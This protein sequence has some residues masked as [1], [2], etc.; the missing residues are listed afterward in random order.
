MYCVGADTIK[1]EDFTF[2]RTKNN[3]KGS[4]VSPFQLP[5]AM[6]PLFGFNSLSIVPTP[7][8]ALKC[9]RVNS[10]QKIFVNVCYHDDAPKYPITDP[11]LCLGNEN[12]IGDTREDAI[13]TYDVIMHSSLWLKINETPDAEDPTA[14]QKAVDFKE[15]V[16][17]NY[18]YQCQQFPT[19]II[20]CCLL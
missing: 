15:K 18:L 10:D 5:K 16:I 11:Y 9:K 8:V 14:Q 20:S 17:I 19:K 2:P 1:M 3:Y 4:A 7:A 12:Y 6:P 13:L